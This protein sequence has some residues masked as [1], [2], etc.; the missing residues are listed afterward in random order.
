MQQ[1][2]NND[3]Q[4]T[5][6]VTPRQRRAPKK[7]GARASTKVFYT[8]LLFFILIFAIAL[9]FVMSELKDWLVDYQASQPEDKCNEVFTQLFSEPDWQEIYTLA[10]E[11]DSEAVNAQSY[12]AYMEEKI[13]DTELTCI[14]TSAGLSGDKKYIV[15][16]GTEKVATFTLTNVTP[17]ASIAT[18]EMG[19]VD[20]FYSCDLSVNII[21]IPG[22]QVKVN[23]QQLDESHIIS[24]E[25][26]KAE[27]YLPE[28]VHGYQLCEMTVGKFLSEPTVEVLD[29]NGSAV[30]LS[31]DADSRTYSHAIADTQKDLTAADDEYQTLLTAAKTYCEYMIGKMGKAELKQCFDAETEI[32]NT[33][34]TNTTWLQKFSG[35]NFGEE[36]IDNYYR[37]NENLYSARVQLTLNVT[38]KDGTIKEFPLSS[39]FFVEKRG[40][41]QWLVINMVNGDVQEHQNSV[42]LTYVVN[43]E[44]VFSELVDAQSSRLTTPEV[45]VPEGKTFAGWF[46]ERVDENGKVSMDLV[47]TPGEDGAVNIPTGTTLEP[48]T[49]QARFQ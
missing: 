5:P 46:V 43:G 32:Y 19:V 1:M 11:Q 45:T 8:C 13:G 7:K 21:T 37:Y 24:M 18:W 12:A 41:D 47:F 33:I 25:S 6:Q 17:D 26:T 35:Y 20:V 3:Q 28:G 48:M 22:Y 23:G 38:R 16:C 34:V 49:L 14:E 39:T 27:E 15:R 40:D 42:R 30:T 31:F 36:T 29:H 2:N 44:T 9:T 10:G 4:N